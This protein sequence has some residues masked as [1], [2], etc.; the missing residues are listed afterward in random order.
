MALSLMQQTQAV[1]ADVTNIASFVYYNVEGFRKIVKKFDK[2]CDAN[3]GTFFL[4]MLRSHY[5]L[6]DDALDQII[7]AISDVFSM[8]RT[9]SAPA[10]VGSTWNPPESFERSTTKYIVK[11]SDVVRVKLMIT[12]HLPILIVGRKETTSAMVPK[13]MLKVADNT[14]ISSVYFDNADLDSY[15]ERILRK[16]GARLFRL[17]WYGDVRTPDDDEQVF[18]ERKTHHE[19]WAMESSVKERFGMKARDV[20]DFL[21]GKFKPAVPDN[22]VALAD[23]I[24]TE[25]ISRAMRPVVR[26]VYQRTAF[27]A[28]SSNDVRIS[29]DTGLSFMDE[30]HGID[31]GNGWCRRIPSEGVDSKDVM[32]FPWAVLEVKLTAGQPPW[33]ES[34]LETGLLHE[35]QKFSKFSHGVATIHEGAGALRELPYW[36]DA[37]RCDHSTTNKASRH[38][39][40]TQE[41]VSITPENYF[42]SVG[43]ASLIES[44]LH[45]K[46]TQNAAVPREGAS[47]SGS[48]FSSWR[49]TLPRADTTKSEA[50]FSSLRASSSSLKLSGDVAPKRPAK[51]EPKTYFANERTFIQWISPVMALVM[52]AMGLQGAGDFLGSSNVVIIGA[53]LNAVGVTWMLFALFM[54]LRR[55]R[56]LQRH[57]STGWG[58]RCG[59]AV[60][61]ILLAVVCV[62]GSI[63][64]LASSRT[65]FD[66]AY[67]AVHA[68]DDLPLSFA[69]DRF[70]RGCLETPLEL[71]GVRPGSWEIQEEL[72]AGDFVTADQRL[73]RVRRWESIMTRFVI[74]H[75]F[76]VEER[77]EHKFCI[78]GVPCDQLV[79]RHRN[80][81]PDESYAIFK[82]AVTNGSTIAPQAAQGQR[83]WSKLEMNAYCERQ[84]LGYSLYVANPPPVTSWIDAAAF[85]GLTRAPILEKESIAAAK[86]VTVSKYHQ[87]SYEYKLKDLFGATAKVVLQWSYFTETDRALGRDAARMEISV[88]L[89]GGVTLSAIRRA[90]GLLDALIRS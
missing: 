22:L 66:A 81:A 12:K 77:T 56:K 70:K 43:D 60:L 64:M 18:V 73:T 53:V 6:K 90:E 40:N 88:K 76:T 3:C 68:P 5:C 78:Q 39:P 54:Y 51:V 23:E 80:I 32:Q 41:H 85:A 38:A 89:E 31:S 9:V 61:V 44:N 42:Q 10:A 87:T 48:W 27:Q 26:T 25:I 59:P 58:A 47:K 74:I 84:S 36:F 16:E 20:P 75:S 50:W 83:S 28:S 62:A 1:V 69:I 30:L 86:L 19:S 15:H 79:A 35:L 24:Q 13:D 33:V 7:I 2:R 55:L 52:V 14:G 65:P 82:F 45:P 72:H 71:S 57:D 8:L 11:A 67:A 37:I 21:A 34:L 49:P 4:P 29:I 17:R 46:E 63:G